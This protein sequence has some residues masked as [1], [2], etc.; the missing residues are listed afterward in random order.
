MK[1][2][3]NDEQILINDGYSL[4]DIEQI[5]RLRYKF[6]LY[7]T[8]G[9]HEKIL[10]ENAKEKLSTDDFLSG[11]GRAAFHRTSYRKTKNKNYDGI[12]IEKNS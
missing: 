8:K 7:D 1:L 12:L 4:D 3:K 10:L 9:N 2:S 5:K 6:T 11:L